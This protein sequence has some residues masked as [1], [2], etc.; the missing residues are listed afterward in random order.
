MTE[1]L[2]IGHP[3]QQAEL[4]S[5]W[6]AMSRARASALGLRGPAGEATVPRDSS[7]LSVLLL[8]G[9]KNKQQPKFSGRPLHSCHS[10]R[11]RDL[12]IS[13]GVLPQKPGSLSQ[14]ISMII[15]DL[16][17]PNQS[18]AQRPSL[19]GRKKASFSLLLTRSEVRG[20]GA[21]GAAGLGVSARTAVTV[22]RQRALSGSPRRLWGSPQPPLSPSGGAGALR[23]GVA[24]GQSWAIAD[25]P[26][27][28]RGDCCP[29][30]LTLTRRAL[31]AARSSL[32]GGR[33]EFP[34]RPP[35]G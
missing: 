9:G 21:W 2:T 5:S 33:V 25:R 15:I 18:E 8:S 7:F 35:A 20:A 34:E 30:H 12:V 24:A 3:G 19:P 17:Q 31:P 27:P 32:H 14:A 1:R 26:P 22:S 13:S 6:M 4:G 16:S 10:V 11:L 29:R 28:T 23:G